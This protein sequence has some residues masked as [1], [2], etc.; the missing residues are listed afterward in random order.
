MSDTPKV[1]TKGE[2]LAA[3]QRATIVDDLVDCYVH[4]PGAEPQP[5]LSVE[6][7]G[8]IKGFATIAMLSAAPLKRDAA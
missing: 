1:I 2:L 4:V 7:S 8:P 6:A 5:L 3:L